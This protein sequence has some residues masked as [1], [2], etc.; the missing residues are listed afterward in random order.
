MTTATHIAKTGNRRAVVFNQ[1]ST[2]FSV[3]VMQAAAR[4]LYMVVVEDTTGVKKPSVS[5]CSI[6]D[7]VSQFFLTENEIIEIKQLHHGYFAESDIPVRPVVQQ[8]NC[9]VKDFKN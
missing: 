4:G 2:R 8:C 6:A 1:I 5:V 7:I 9:V 3:V